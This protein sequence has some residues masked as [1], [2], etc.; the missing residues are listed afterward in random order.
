MAEVFINGQSYE[1]T[2]GESILDV[3]KRNGI[4][5]PVMC[6]LEHITPTGACR[7]CLVEIEGY[8]K[9]MAACVTYAVDGMKIK[10]DTEMVIEDRKQMMDFILMK[11]PLDCPVCDKAGECMLQ[12]TAFQFGITEETVSVPKPQK[13]IRIWN[14]IIHNENLCIL[15][16]RCVKI[17]HELTGRS[18]LKIEERGFNNYITTADPNG[19]DCDFCGLCVD[20]CPVGALL[21]K[22]FNHK[23]RVWDLQD[24]L[25]TCTYCPSG[26]KIKMSTTDNKIYRATAKDMG[27]I[28]NLGRYG[29]KFVD[30]E[31]RIFNPMIK[32]N[33]TTW[34]DFKAKLPD[35]NPEETAVI[36]G[37]RLTNEA[38]AAY[39]QL[40]PNVICDL[41]FQETDF[42]KK[43][44]EKFGTMNNIG[45]YGQL[46]NSDF[47][48]VI[49]ADFTRE[50][51]GAKWR[52]LSAVTKNKGDMISISIN[53]NEVE[54]YARVA[55]KA[56]YGNFAEKI[57]EFLNSDEEKISFARK[58]FNKAE[59]VSIVVGNEYLSA[60][61]D[62]DSVF[63][64]A[65]VIG[66]DRLVSFLVLNDK[67]NFQGM[68]ASGIIENGYTPEKLLKDIEKGKI[69]N[70]ITADFYP[71]NT[72]DLY[73][74]LNGAF[75]LVNVI[76]VD[77][78]KNDFNLNADF[79]IPVTT[80][81]ETKGTT[82]TIDNR[83]G[84]RAQIV[85]P[86]ETL[87]NDVQAATLLGNK[88]GIE[89]ADSY[90]EIW[91]NYIKG[92]NGYPDVEFSDLKE[93]MFRK[94]EPAFNKSEYKYS[95]KSSKNEK[96]VYI[97]SRYHN[98]F[99][100]T[101][102]V[103][104][105]KLEDAALREYFFDV[106]KEEISHETNENVA[107]GVKLITKNP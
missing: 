56:D 99:V 29:Y 40:T 64:L 34:D 72:S 101:K 107:K 75:E 37:S 79:V 41:E 86:A 51:T 1:F 67:A 103:I 69:Q 65:D 61:T 68:I 5:I 102:A 104:T 77:F 7:L 91:N 15:C 89:S 21:D 94:I 42:Y 59:T 39:K 85:E 74:K 90:E 66:K 17:C 13:E 19:L 6:Y 20:Y 60:E 16:E 27:F 28:C 63:A 24:T 92:Q 57:N 93:M 46:M 45:K 43:Y 47:V 14:K 84:I 38:I 88:L 100:S 76:A 83:I 96:T 18:A 58:M 105:E 33:E 55:F 53:E 106:K 97:N 26:C 12:D 50:V 98:G 35:L 8:S 95:P 4:D 31:D 81:Y 36:L 49:G 25:T 3:A 80:A 10:T 73:A 30:S 44:Q 9:P 62:F 71:Y 54:K 23:I 11:H 32:G 78:L 87:L 82:T 70:V 52:V 48:F 2:E 22:P